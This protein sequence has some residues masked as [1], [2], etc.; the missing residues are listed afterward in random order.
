MYSQP[1]TTGCGYIVSQGVAF[2]MMKHAVCYGISEEKLVMVP[3]EVTSLHLARYKC[4]RRLRGN[5]NSKGTVRK[6]IEL[7]NPSC[8]I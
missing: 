2:V 1:F 3:Y 8:D 4:F 7:V 6:I 5:H